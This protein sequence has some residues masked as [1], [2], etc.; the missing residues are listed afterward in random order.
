[1]KKISKVLSVV[2]AALLICAVAPLTAGALTDEFVYG[3]LW[4][5]EKPFS[6]DPDDLYAHSMQLC[7]F[8]AKTALNAHEDLLEVINLEGADLI[9]WKLWG[10]LYPTVDD[11]AKCNK[12]ADLAVDFCFDSYSDDELNNAVG[13][14]DEWFVEPVIEHKYWFEEKPTAD[15]PYAKTNKTADSLKWYKYT[16][17]TTTKDIVENV[18]NANVQARYDELWE[19]TY[20]AAGYWE[21][22]ACLNDPNDPTTVF[23]YTIDMAVALGVGDVLKITVPDNFDGDV[24]K[25]YDIDIFTKEGN[26]YTY[27]SDAKQSFNF[28]IHNATVAYTVEI[29][30]DYVEY[31]TTEIAGQNKEIYTGNGNQLVACHASFENGKYLLK[32]DMVELGDNWII[33]QPTA[34]VPTLETNKPAVS[35]QWYSHKIVT[36]TYNYVKTVTDSEKEIA[37]DD[38]D[39]NQINSQADLIGKNALLCGEFDADGYIKVADPATMVYATPTPIQYVFD[40]YY[41]FNVGD[42]FKIDITG[43]ASTDPAQPD[44]QLD[45][46]AEGENGWWDTQDFE[47]AEDGSFIIPEG[48]KLFGVY[49]STTN[50]DIKVKVTRS[51]DVEILTPIE[52]QTSKTF[53]GESGEYILKATYANG[54]ELRSNVVKYQKAAPA[55][56]PEQN[57]ENNKPITSPNTG[58][59]SNIVFWLITAIISLAALA[60]LKLAR[61]ELNTPSK[62]NFR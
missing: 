23:D 44:Y 3:G 40:G 25:Y 56:A 48:A 62:Q 50:S 19:G 16:P 27:T 34:D 11:D 10:V 7:E 35:Y 26:V 37:F 2:L 6:G 24:H 30:V 38:V 22:N 8:K 13:N 51:T 57:V 42:R 47:K 39:F 58:D 15:Y 36:K 21:S 54:T 53:T 4:I 60:G 14:Y 12:I 20:N 33:A 45:V 41:V 1:M 52:G 32:T 61:N 46:Y 9:G 5:D 28:Y 59:S 43:S 17:K 31:D 29:S 55:P 18:T 49:L